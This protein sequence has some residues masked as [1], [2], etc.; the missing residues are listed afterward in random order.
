[1]IFMLFCSMGAETGE[2][3]AQ[4]YGSYSVPNHETVVRQWIA[5]PSPS[6]DVILV[7]NEP[8]PSARRHVWYEIIKKVCIRM[9]YKTK[10][11][12][13]DWKKDYT[14][15]VNGF[16]FVCFKRSFSYEI[17]LCWRHGIDSE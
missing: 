6:L 1:M 13:T 14:T 9:I 16:S 10:T 5:I 4:A 12:T 17:R 3:E 2:C 7:P 15:N 8:V 11:K